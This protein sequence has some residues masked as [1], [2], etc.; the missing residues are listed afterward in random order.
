MSLS[1]L[2]FK[3]TRA[4]VGLVQF[5]ASLSESHLSE[6]DITDHPVEE[7]ANIADHIRN[8]PDSIEINGVVTNT[9][10]AYLASLTA[11]S[12]LTSD[13][14]SVDDRVETAYQELL[15][16]KN[17]G[18]LVEVITSLRTYKN[19]VLKSVSVV[20]DQANGN[21]LNTSVALREM[22]IA[23][24]LSVDL[25]IPAEVVDKVKTK[26]GKKSK[27]AATTKQ[28]E[29]SLELLNQLLGS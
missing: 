8:R 12:P 20:R 11:K 28:N 6:A 5:D 19:M 2:L 15:R 25:P 7:G 22:L 29:T 14:G 17:T 3:K 13:L 18:E 26:K 27:K 16:I 4:V 1:E 10:I 23:N 21:I 24:A 9:P